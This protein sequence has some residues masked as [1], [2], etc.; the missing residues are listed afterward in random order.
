MRRDADP[1]GLEDA[2]GDQEEPAEGAM[3]DLGLRSHFRT[4]GGEPVGDA[5]VRGWDMHHG[6]DYGSEWDRDGEHDE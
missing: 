2:L 4:Q 1:F 6:V 5:V 3:L